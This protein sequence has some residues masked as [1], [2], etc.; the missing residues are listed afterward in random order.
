[1]SLAGVGGGIGGGGVAEAGVDENL[2]R[3]PSY[4]ILQI[5]MLLHSRQTLLRD[6]IQVKRL[7]VLFIVHK[8]SGLPRTAEL[9]CGSRHF[10]AP[11]HRRHAAFTHSRRNLTH[12]G[13]SGNR[14]SYSS[15]HGR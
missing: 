6:Y 13:T 12:F 10:A 14:L 8:F 9:F 4:F 15:L 3:I 5:W 11:T 1:M 2:W 7:L